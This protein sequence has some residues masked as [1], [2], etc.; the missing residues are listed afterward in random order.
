MTIRIADV[1]LVK[2]EYYKTIRDIRKP[3]MKPLTAL[4]SINNKRLAIHIKKVINM[5][6]NFIEGECNT[7]ELRCLVTKGIGQYMQYLKDRH[8]IK[9]FT[10]ICNEANNTPKIIDECNIV[11]DIYWKLTNTEDNSYFQYHYN[12]KE[13]KRRLNEESKNNTTHL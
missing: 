11:I 7:K 5:Y 4:D 9:D 12:Y 8:A 1:H 13:H 3:K 2:N 10:I 6:H